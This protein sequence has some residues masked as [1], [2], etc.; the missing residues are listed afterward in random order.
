MIGWSYRR[1]SGANWYPFFIIII[2]YW[3]IFVESKISGD[4]NIETFIGAD[5]GGLEGG[6]SP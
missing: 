3:N 4:K 1:G 6:A 5:G 2:F